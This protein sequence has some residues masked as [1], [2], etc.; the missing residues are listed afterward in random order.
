VQRVGFDRAAWIS[1]ATVVVGLAA[2]AVLGRFGYMWIAIALVLVAA[3][4]RVN[5][6]VAGTNVLR[7][8]PENRT[9]IGAALVDTA[10]EV[11]TG[12]GVAVTGTILAAIFTGD[13]ATSNWSTQQ[14]TQFRDAITI[15]GLMLAV[16]A[17]T[18]VAWGIVRTRHRRVDVTHRGR[19]SGVGVSTRMAYEWFAD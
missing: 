17:A 9:S 12:V 19:R 15:A 11:A 8:L 4:I 7:G 3:G 13:I 18:L 2:Y 10:S 5:G 1:A 16:V 14:T 6:V